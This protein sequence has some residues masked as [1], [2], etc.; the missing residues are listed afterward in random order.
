MPIAEFMPVGPGSDLLLDL[1]TRSAAVLWGHPV[2]AARRAR[3]DI[4]VSMIWLF[5]GSGRAPEMPPFEEAYGLKAALTSG[6][7]LLHGLAQ[8]VGMESLKIAGVS[9]G[10]DNDYAAQANGALKA[11][12]GH[13]LVVVHIEAPDEAGHA[14]SINDKVAAIERID[15][16]VVRRL[17]E[18]KDDGLRVLILPDHPTPIELKTHSPEPVPFLLWGPGFEANGAKRFTE[19]EAAKTGLFID[20]GYNIMGRLTGRV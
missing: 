18:Y 6:V 17:G 20:P 1:M 7:D 8:M 11:L 14:G 3:G 12:A 15:G 9:D 5:W 19:V 16:E 10:L 4:P 13:D 2:N